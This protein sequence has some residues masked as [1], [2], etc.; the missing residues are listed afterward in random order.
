M[1]GS[2]VVGLDGAGNSVPAVRW[3]AEEAAARGLPLHLLHSWVSQPLNLPIA[4]EA[5]NKKRY[6]AEVL[7]SAE[8]MALELHPGISVTA[9]Q[10]SEQ[11]VDALVDRSRQATMM[12]LGSRGHG[13]IAGFLLGSV[14]LH[15]LGRAQ[16]PVVTVREEEATTYGRPEVVVGVQEAGTQGEAVLDFAFSAAEAHHTSVRAWEPATVTD[17]VPTAPAHPPNDEELA[18]GEEKKL[19]GILAPWR[20]KFPDVDVIAHVQRGRIAPV[21]LGT[22]SQ[23]RL[24]VVGR[25]MHR[26]PMLLGPVVFAALHHSFCPVAVVPRI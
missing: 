26:T 6:G 25:R 3:G 1:G 2:V 16:C 9:E 13:A 4:Q 10:V 24:L 8:A 19:A 20:A 22:C 17:F 23:A 15:V 14:S 12:V 21:L 7:E 11:A 18:A 5:A